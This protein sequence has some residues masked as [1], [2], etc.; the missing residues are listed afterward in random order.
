MKE[1]DELINNI[2]C[3][4]EEK[5]N[6]ILQQAKEERKKLRKIAIMICVIIDLIG[7]I[8]FLAIASVGIEFMLIAVFSLIILNIT[9]Y[10]CIVIGLNKKQ[11][12]FGK[13]F[14]ENII[15]KI[16]ENFYEN[17]EYFPT[18]EM[19]SKFYDEAFTESYDNYYSEDYFEAMLNGKY[20]FSLAEI[21]TEKVIEEKDKEGHV[22]RREETVFHGLF[23]KVTMN[24]SINCNF[25]IDQNT[26]LKLLNRNLKMDSRRV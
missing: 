4:N 22:T 9:I 5:F 24:K 16:S 15:G 11:K 10:M 3:E 19:P 14:K 13:E 18:K 23:E 2:K 25:R 12:I 1:Y 20:N 6:K 21:K 8:N 17:V 26:F 7:L